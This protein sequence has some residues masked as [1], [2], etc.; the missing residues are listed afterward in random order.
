[1]DSRNTPASLAWA[2]LLA[3]MLAG[4]LFSQDPVTLSQKGLELM[5]QGRF[6]E[7]EDF[8]RNAI[9][10]AGS[11]NTTALYN[12][13]TL[14][15]RQG[16]LPE[17]ERMHRHALELIEQKRGPFHPEVAESLNALGSL[18]RSLGRFSQAIA[19]LERAVQ[20]LDRHPRP[21]VACAVLNGLASI[22][23]DLG[24]HDTA[25]SFV[26]RALAIAES[27]ICDA[28]DR[29]YIFGNLGRGH[30]LRNQLVEAEAT[31]REVISIFAGTLGARHP[32]YAG[33][34]I[35]LAIVQ[36]RQGRLQQAL[37]LLESAIDILERSYGREAPILAANLQIYAEL[38]KALGRK[39]EAREVA[40][41]ASSLVKP[42]AGTVDVKAL[43]QWP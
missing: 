38:L 25:D 42:K 34:L 39:S 41:R 20:I 6:R 7:A 19:I 12:L 17:A 1:M 30:L 13:A 2:C 31:Y 28:I 18:Y 37:P 5:N 21:S 11:A 43:R 10:I 32:D 27:G 3:I 8:L 15:Q 26:R 35:N 23:Y 14:Y 33:A 16:R 24:Q 9:E 4:R 29:G 22:H 36:Q 40:R